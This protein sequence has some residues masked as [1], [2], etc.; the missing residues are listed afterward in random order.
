MNAIDINNTPA[1]SPHSD[2]NW[3]LQNWKKINRYVKRL[4]QRIFRARS[5]QSEKESKK[6]SKANVKKQSQSITLD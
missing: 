2:S 6:T 4:R 1:Y 5:D 3:E